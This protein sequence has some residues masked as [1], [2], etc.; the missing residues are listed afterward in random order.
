MK[1]CDSKRGKKAFVHRLFSRLSSGSDHHFSSKRNSIETNNNDAKES[2]NA[3]KTDSLKFHN[4]SGKTKL[5]PKISNK[6][7]VTQNEKKSTLQNTQKKKRNDKKQ[8]QKAAKTLSAILLAFIVTWT[9]YNVFT[10]IQTFYKCAIPPTLYN[11][12]ELVSSYKAA[13]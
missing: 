1:G 12:G 5:L 4:N 2:N 8:D 3:A 10:V 9:P 11:F 6:S 13:K 7:E